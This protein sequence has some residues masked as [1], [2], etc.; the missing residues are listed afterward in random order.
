MLI[1][2]TFLRYLQQD[3]GLDLDEFT[4]VDFAKAILRLRRRQRWSRLGRWLSAGNRL[5]PTIR[6]KRRFPSV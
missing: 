6:I 4:L 1:S 3:A 2:G 5:D